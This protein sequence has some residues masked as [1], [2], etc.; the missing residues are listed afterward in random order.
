MSSHRGERIRW[1]YG[2]LRILLVVFLVFR[3]TATS[4]ERQPGP[5]DE[6]SDLTLAL[7]SGEKSD[8]LKKSR[9]GTKK[10]RKKS[11]KHLNPEEQK[12]LKKLWKTRRAHSLK[13]YKKRIIRNT[14]SK[15]DGKPSP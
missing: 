12:R 6:S 3:W 5:E 1:R 9:K 2:F 8:E 7:L 10:A 15:S 14:R 13:P 4:E 11:E